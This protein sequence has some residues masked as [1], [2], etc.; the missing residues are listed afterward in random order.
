MTQ[1]SPRTIKPRPLTD[2]QKVQQAYRGHIQTFTST[3]Q[4]V[5][6][7]LVH[8]PR[9]AKFPADKLAKKALD[10][11][12]AFTDFVEIEADASFMRKVERLKAEG[13]EAE[14]DKEQEA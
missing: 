4:G 2:E 8:N 9:L 3:A 1:A 13:A 11:T 5:L 7:N 6:F 14:K 12:A 10:I